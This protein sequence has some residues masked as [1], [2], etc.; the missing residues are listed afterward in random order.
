MSNTLVMKGAPAANALTEELKIR[1]DRLREKGI[2][3][4]LAI[5]RVGEDPSAISY[6]TGAAKRAEKVGVD[7]K[8][9]ILPED[10]TEDE[11]LSAVGAINE[12][13]S[14]HGCL[15]FRP[16]KDRR[17]E[18]RA[19]ALLSAG[20]DVDCMTYLSQAALYM[21]QTVAKSG[22]APGAAEKAGV[23]GF[24][25]C[26]AQAVLELLKYY[27]I[28]V[29]GKNVVIIGRSQVIGKPVA[30]L[31]LEAN[32][33]VTVCHSK[34]EKLEAV[35]RNADIVVAA[36]GRA[37]MIDENYLREGQVVIDVGINVGEDGKLCGDVKESAK[38]TLTAA[39]TPVPGGVGAMTTT[40][41]MKHVL[42]AAE[43]A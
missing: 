5:L 29:T 23:R 15:M 43:K 2:I 35:V 38:E 37:G 3:P 25:P 8:N 20:K 18:E 7:I 27:E 33:T 9:I 42:E 40:V 39:Y 34:T 21:G 4:R 12:D 16:L 6:E 30:M 41:L 31:L 28:P 1:A 13:N 17:T 32:A 36:I 14:I 10:A 26:T 24:A 11:I 22:A 19:S